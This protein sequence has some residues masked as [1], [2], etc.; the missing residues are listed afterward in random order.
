MHRS[1]PVR[2]SPA[3]AFQP[4]AAAMERTGLLDDIWEHMRKAARDVRRKRRVSR[5]M[6]AGSVGAAVQSASGKI[7]IGVCVDTCCTL[8]ICAERNAMF[9]M[10]TAGEDAVRKVVAV[11]GNGK[12]WPPC[13][14]CR[15]FIVQLMPDS[16]KDVEILLEGESGPRIVTMRELAPDWWIRPV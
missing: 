5:Y 16:Y 15:E 14:A 6:D 11:G 12:L 1:R 3:V 9:Q 7:Y 8:G 10:L 4:K 2:Q 13:G